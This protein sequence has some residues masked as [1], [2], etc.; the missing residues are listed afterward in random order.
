MDKFLTPEEFCLDDIFKGRYMIPVYQRPYSWGEKQIKQ[1]LDDI[2]EAYK[3]YKNSN[4]LNADDCVL[5]TGTMFIKTEANI[6]NEYTEYTV[7]DG[8]QRITTLTLLLMSLLNHFY[9]VKS[10]DDVVGEIRNYLWKKEDR[11]NDKN[12]QV[13][14]LGNIDAEIL[15]A[16][17]N[18]LY[19]GNDIVEFAQRKL[20][21]SQNEIE[22]NL[23]NNFLTIN[24]HF[25]NYTSEN[26]FYEYFDF[27]KYNIKIISIKINTNMVKLFSIFESINSKGKPL[28]EIDL[29]K[30]YI[31]QNIDQSDY[32]EYLDKWGELIR[33]T[34]D[35]LSDYFTVYIRANISYYRTS[36][37]LDNF[38]ILAEGQL[39][40]YYEVDKLCDVLKAFI[41]DMLKQ[42]KFYKMM[43]DYAMLKNAGV[44]EKSRSFFMMN[45]LAKYNN[46]DPIYF[47]LL[48]LRGNGISDDKFDFIVDIAFRFILT[49]QTICSRESKQ[50]ITVFSDVQNEIYSVAPKKD[51]IVD[52][53]DHAVENIKYIYNKAIYDNSISNNGLKTSIRNTMTYKKNKNVVKLLLAYLLEY[54]QESRKVDY[55]K[56]NS[57]LG[58]GGSIH[59]DHILPQTPDYSDSGFKYYKEG[60]FM[61]LKPG[62]DFT[63][64]PS[65]ERMP[66]DIF[67]NTYLHRFGNLRLE[68]ADDNIRKSNDLIKL[69]EFDDLFNCNSKIMDR[70]KEL[71]DKLIESNFLISMDNYD[72]VPSSIKAKRQIEVESNTVDDIA[73]KDYYPIGFSLFGTKFDL[74]KFNY[75][76]LLVELFD[77]LYDLE[78]DRLIELAQNRFV[79][80]SSGRIYIS[81]EKEDVVVPYA[82]GNSVYIETKLSSDYI[83]FFGYKVIDEMGLDKSD[84]KVILEER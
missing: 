47:K 75:K 79:P 29:I 58:L 9:V 2:D 71:I 77:Q 33:Q 24:D 70:E 30:S 14:T 6:R 52:V 72:F 27:I 11:K 67:L 17:L 36:I 55:L 3:L 54:N 25:E 60:D 10:D 80:T 50:T 18:E 12:K 21:E 69:E 41:N 22:K 66:V 82:L 64:D 23:L 65:Q 74:S 34:N 78:K 5:F 8:Q 84:L 51:S 63:E 61:M 37:K 62:Q 57:I 45:R 44:S 40:K 48:S 49:F 7:V 42:V 56:L 53:D 1:L 20:N 38:K 81:S 4:G 26:E 16:L 39:K 83:M 68:W 46:T 31:F 59:V 15:K 19:S 35:R 73:F 28:E 43:T 32:D 76:Q 13:L